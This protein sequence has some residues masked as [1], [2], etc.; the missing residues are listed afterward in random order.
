MIGIICFWDRYAIPYLAKYEE[1]LNEMNLAYEVLFW[2][3]SPS[4]DTELISKS[5]NEITI[6]LPCIG[7]K[8]SKLRAFMRWRSIAKKII[9]K[10]GY[11]HL[12]VLSTVPAVL[13][14]WTLL[15]VYKDNYLFDIRD[16]TLE[17]NK[18]FKQVVMKLINNSVLT[19]ISSKGYMRW[20]NTSPKIMV[21]HNITVNEEIKPNI[22]K[23]KIKKIINF[24]FVGNV[25]LDSQTEALLLALKDE[26]RIEQHYYGR[27]IPGC[28]IQEIKDEYNIENL[29]LHGA[30]AVSD[31][32]HIF[33]DVD[34]INCVYANAKKE[35]DIPLGDS[36]PLPNRLYDSIIFY[37]PIVASKGTYLAELVEQYH[38]GCCINGFDASA[39]CDILKYVDSFD[40]SVFVSG[41]N[42]L[43]SVVIKEEKEYLKTVKKIFGN[44]RVE[45]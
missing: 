43:K 12:I 11:N 42:A 8:L 41:C 34:L 5:A 25:R 29:F 35:Q 30:F 27:I 45:K 33:A 23:L 15:K 2:N 4:R 39:K 38:L 44:W 10:N 21:N 18:I 7:S 24:A 6:N 14:Y 26:H 28:R 13:M 31:K 37:R 40:E 9:K 22:P 1:L 19:S 16:Y 3:R 36:T 20:L 17:N 32:T